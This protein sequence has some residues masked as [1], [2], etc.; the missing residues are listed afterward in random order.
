MI[1]LVSFLFVIVWPETKVQ[2]NVL[3]CS[4]RCEISPQCVIIQTAHHYLNQQKRYK[5]NSDHNFT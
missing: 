3:V 1:H 4:G 5:C 2:L